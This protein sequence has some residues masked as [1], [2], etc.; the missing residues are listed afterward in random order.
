MEQIKNLISKSKSF[1]LLLIVPSRYNLF[2]TSRFLVYRTAPIHN[3]H[4]GVL[5][6]GAFPRAREGNPEQGFKMAKKKY[7]TIS[8]EKRYTKDEVN[9]IWNENERAYI[10]ENVD[11]NR[12]HKNITLAPNPY[13]NYDDFVERKNPERKKPEWSLKNLTRKPIGKS[14]KV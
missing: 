4:K 8:Q 6:F 7:A 3:N 10:P 2:Y 12:L 9:N 13:K 14:T 1:D 11:K 5:C